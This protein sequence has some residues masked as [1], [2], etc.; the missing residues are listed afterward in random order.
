MVLTALE[1][2]WNAPTGPWV[3]PTPPERPFGATWG[4][5][6]SLGIWPGQSGASQ[7]ISRPFLCCEDH[8][9]SVWIC[10]CLCRKPILFCKYLSPLKS[11]KIDS[12]FKI[13]IWISVF[14]RKKRCWNPFIGSGDIK[15]TNIW[16]F[17]LKRPVD[18]AIRVSKAASEPQKCRS[19]T[20]NS[21]WMGLMA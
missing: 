16:A 21:F 12:V 4:P 10:T 2:P 7:G 6:G 1:W 8:F 13:Y 11:H 17:F 5:W 9:R 15:Q 19:M 14:R 20:L 18:M 3:A